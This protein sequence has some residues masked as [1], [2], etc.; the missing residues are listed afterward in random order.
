LVRLHREN[1]EKLA[2]S[3]PRQSRLLQAIGN[4]EAENLGLL[5][6]PMHFA[7]LEV[8]A[9]PVEHV[10]L[11]WENVSSLERMHK[12]RWVIEISYQQ[13]DEIAD[14]YSL[15]REE[16][17]TL[18]DGTAGNGAR[19][20]QEN[21]GNPGQ[22]SNTADAKDR[23]AEAS[24]HGNTKRVFCCWHRLNRR[25]YVWV[26]GIHR[27]LRNESYAGP[28]PFVPFAFSHTPKRPIPVSIGLAGWKLQREIN[29]ML[30]EGKQARRARYPKY[31]I[32]RGVA[33]VEDL[34]AITQCVPHGVVE[35]D[36]PEELK[37]AIEEFKGTEYDPRLFD[38]SGHMRLMEI[39]MGVT[40]QQVGLSSS[41]STATEV[42]RAAAG[43]AA[44]NNMHQGMLYKAL[45]KLYAL[46]LGYV[47][48]YVDPERVAFIISAEDA[49]IWAAF[50]KDREQIAAGLKVDILAADNGAEAQMAQAK[51]WTVT[52]DS[53]ARVGQAKVTLAQAGESLNTSPIFEAITEGMGLGISGDELVQKMPPPQPGMMPQGQPGGNPGGMNMAAG[54]SGQP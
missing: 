28:A 47:A 45:R 53:L 25:R 16:L 3:D 35:M 18:K 31:G 37:K 36:E 20:H 24:E 6:E 50:P 51:A 27:F 34:L 23:D 40:M 13:P 43:A 48:E 46:T 26:E 10:R 12:G 8:S 14:R 9:V 22:G 11:D 29:Q 30:T 38:P 41:G 1:A 2:A 42:E 49:Q 52:A 7:G 4:P 44:T 19:D 21:A 33:S 39:E 54:L 5:P 15:S 17:Q 32:K